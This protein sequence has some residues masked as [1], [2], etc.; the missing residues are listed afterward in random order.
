MRRVLCLALLTAAALLGCADKQAPP[1]QIP[2][3]K[4]G[5]APATTVD[6]DQQLIAAG[7]KLRAIIPRSSMDA[8]LQQGPVWLL[9]RVPIEEVMEKGKFVGWRVLE[10]PLSWKTLDLKPGDVVTRVNAMTLET[11][12]DFFAA[13]TTLSVASEL[14][15]A[16]L[17]DGDEMEM[18]FPI[19]GSPDPALAQRMQQQGKNT[20][21]AASGEPAGNPRYRQPRVKK[22][23]VI[24]GEDRPLSD[25]NVDWSQ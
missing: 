7:G 18:S 17:R 15:V 6:A 2:A 11:P 8:V 21:A 10:L 23:I 12:S 16:Y 5:P 25:T 14:K 20:P 13:W 1:L 19:D 24:K 3:P 4:Q 22:T 9:E